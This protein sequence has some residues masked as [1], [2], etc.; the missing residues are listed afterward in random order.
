MRITIVLDLF[1]PILHVVESITPTVHSL[2]PCDVIDKKGT[3]S[4]SIVRTS[5]RAEIFLASSIPDLKLDVFVVNRNSLC[6]E[7]DSDGY[8]VSNPGLVLDELEYDTRFSHS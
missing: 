3:N 4:T 5:N 2:L 7:F 6:S 8:I 1:K